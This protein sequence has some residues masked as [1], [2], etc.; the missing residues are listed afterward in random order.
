MQIRDWGKSFEVIVVTGG[1]LIEDGLKSIG[2]NKVSIPRNFYK[3]VYVPEKQEMIGFVMPNQK[4]YNDL[5]SYT[6]TVDE[7]EVLT[8][9][10]F[11]IELSEEQQ[12]QLE[13]SINLEN[14]VFNGSS[15]FENTNPST[16]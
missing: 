10:N 16:N 9:L 8:G 13:S 7:I 15:S 3:I 1:V 12:N 5:L 4:I 14:W 6:R 11:F 2:E